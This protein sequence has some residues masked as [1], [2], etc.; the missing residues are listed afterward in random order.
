MRKIKIQKIFKRKDKVIDLGRSFS[1][2]NHFV[3]HWRFLV[4]IFAVGM[5]SLSIFSW[6]IYLSDKIGG[7]YLAPAVE[8]PDTIVRTI[9]Q[10]K[11]EAVLK[12]LEDRQ[13]NFLKLKANQPKLIDPAL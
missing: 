2:P 10:K 13:I 9:D 4:L 7:G 6:Q 5:I 12:I 8:A 11:L 3:E 1:W